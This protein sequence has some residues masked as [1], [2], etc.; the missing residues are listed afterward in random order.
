M[1]QSLHLTPFFEELISTINMH[2]ASKPAP[3]GFL[4]AAEIL[5]LKAVQCLVIEDAPAGV[6]AAKSA[7]MKCLATGTS[8]P[9]E[10]LHAADL[11]T[12]TLE[13]LNEE[14]VIK[15]LEK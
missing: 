4:K 12:P 8:N 10:N 3:D 15:L 1:T 5:G 11:V 9:L 6:A 7:G 2:L 13:D 14:D